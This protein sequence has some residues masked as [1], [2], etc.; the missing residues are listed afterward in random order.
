MLKDGQCPQVLVVA[1]SDSRVDPAI[2]TQCDPGDLFVIRN[3]AN[4]IPP[5][6]VDEQTYHGTSAAIEFAVR[7]LN[8]K[9]IIVLGHSKCGGIQY[10][11]DD[12]NTQE[13]GVNSDPK[14][15]KTKGGVSFLKK[16]TEIGVNAKMKTIRMNQQ[17]AQ[18]M[19]YEESVEFCSKMSIIYSIRNLGTFPWIFLKN[20]LHM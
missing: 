1:C 10:L 18:P 16:W 13:K 14:S 17:R 11:L 2:I 3:V 4:L 15:L 19:T 12:E 8:V 9:D 5:Y 7:Y 6:E 20:N